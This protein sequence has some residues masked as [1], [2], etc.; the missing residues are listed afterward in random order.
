MR[1]L[2]VRIRFT[3]HCLGNVKRFHWEK[4]KKRSFFLLPKNP[5]GR[6]IFL[7]TWW[8]ALLTKAAEVACHFQDEVKK[9][10]FSLEVDGLPRPVPE[11]F[12]RRYY[13]EGRFSK[14]EAFWPGDTVGVTCLV[15]DTINDEEFHRL[16]AL[17]GRYWGI[18]PAKPNEYGFFDV[19]SVQPCGPRRRME[20][21]IREQEI[22]TVKSEPPG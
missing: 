17:I 8:K 19:V 6:V 2:T 13:D 5:E 7:P 3:K 15:P 9:I 22:E 14:H 1:E 11:H 18:S 16:M 20:P 4:G 10:S 21:I 12:F